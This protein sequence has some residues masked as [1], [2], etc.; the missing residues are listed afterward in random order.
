MPRVTIQSLQKSLAFAE[1]QKRVL[2]ERIRILEIEKDN[3]ELEIIRLK[4]RVADLET[5][6]ANL[7]SLLI[8]T[9]EPPE[10]IQN[11]KR[12]RPVTIT[13][14]QRQQVKDLRERGASLRTICRETGLSLG[15][16]HKIVRDTH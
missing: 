14:E 2:A 11:P 7:R 12:G 4:Q 10:P 8:E 15:A 5:E 9:P 13:Q 6:L 1:E 16:V 3:N